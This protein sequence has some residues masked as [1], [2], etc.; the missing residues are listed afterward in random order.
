M[1][2]G[3]QINLLRK[4]KN[5]SQEEL[6]AEMDV[7]RQSVSKWETGLSR[8]DTENLIRLAKILEVDVNVLIGSPEV[9]SPALLRRKRNAL[10]CALSIFL[11]VSI[12]LATVFAVLWQAEKSANIAKSTEE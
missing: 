11:A 4:Q 1:T 9:S 7:S 3:Q 8:P 5:L 10:V 6:A 2:L 12:S